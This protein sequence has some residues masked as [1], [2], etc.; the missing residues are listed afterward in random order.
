M[1]EF[2]NGVFGKV[3]ANKLAS[4]HVSGFIFICFRIAAYPLDPTKLFKVGQIA[5]CKVIKC[6]AEQPFLRLSFIV[7]LLC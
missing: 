6:N 7:I 3:P 1:M 4:E 2:F 5:A